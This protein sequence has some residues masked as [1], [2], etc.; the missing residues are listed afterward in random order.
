MSALV[1]TLTKT[2]L[3][4]KIVSRS[5]SS[6]SSLTSDIGTNLLSKIDL[7]KFSN[8]VGKTS[9]VSKGISKP[10][11]SIVNAADYLNDFA[12]IVPSS[13]DEI[14]T[15][16]IKGSDNLSV[17]TSVAQANSKTFKNVKNATNAIS[18]STSSVS[19]LLLDSAKLIPRIGDDILEESSKIALK[20]TKSVD[21]VSEVGSILKK[22][23]GVSKI[24]DVADST[25]DIGGFS[26]KLDEAGD[27]ANTAK[28]TGKISKFINSYG[29]LVQ[30][31]VFSSFLLGSYITSKTTEESEV[32]PL[33]WT[34][35]PESSVYDIES[36]N[37]S[38]IIIGKIKQNSE[39]ISEALIEPKSIFAIMLI[40]SIII[41][42]MNLNSN[43]K[44]LKS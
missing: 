34:T 38:P 31:G 17:S 19:P 28:N 10:T 39:I 4:S 12:K 24:D 37:D 36:T 32:D 18:S 5:L 44:F 30:I 26:K 9:D 2:G 35:D 16:I 7:Q 40:S 6:V 29:A 1:K 41:Y 43:R 11:S 20:V 33:V 15:T 25:S 8:I 23:K 22:S 21:D 14:M 42:N 27:A 3:S 13:T